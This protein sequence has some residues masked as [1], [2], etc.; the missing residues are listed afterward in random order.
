M[1]LCVLTFNSF[2]W[3]EGGEGDDGGST[4]SKIGIEGLRRIFGKSLHLQVEVGD[5]TS[6]ALPRHHLLSLVNS[7][8]KLR[9]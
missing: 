3:G 9:R 2:L 5:H 7:K 6:S 8:N 4:Y 1:F